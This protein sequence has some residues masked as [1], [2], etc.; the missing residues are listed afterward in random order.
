MSYLSREQ[1]IDAL[2][3]MRTFH[4]ECSELFSKHGFDLMQNLGRR[5]IVMSQAHE[6]FFAD[7]IS[8]AQEGVTYDGRT[9]QADI[10]IGGLDKELECKLTS[11]HQSGAISFH[12]DYETLLQKESLDYLYVVADD[13]FEKF[14]VLHFE[15]LTVDDFRPLSNGS[16][17]KVAMYKHKGMKKCRVLV[18]QA[19]N[20]REKHLKTIRAAMTKRSLTP[21]Q[22]CRLQKRLDY[23]KAA[24]ASYT[25][26]PEALDAN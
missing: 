16:R 23:W 26:V 22:R 14:V 8:R 13:N 25:Y 17:G 24:P 5:N 1:S 9:G 11:R 6:K 3:Q 10:V 15:N 2:R 12:S 21:K 4:A 7:V 19:Q 20:N 18:G